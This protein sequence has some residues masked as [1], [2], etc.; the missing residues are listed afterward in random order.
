MSAV[1][2]TQGKGETSAHHADQSNTAV[3]LTGRV[4]S[5][6]PGRFGERLRVEHAVLS[7]Q[8]GTAVP[9]RP[10]FLALHGWG[11]NEADLAQLM[12]YIAPYNDF[13]ALRAPL[14]LQETPGP[15]GSP[16]AFSWFHDSVPTGE[17]L[18]RDAYAASVAVDDWVANNI[19]PDRPVVPIGFSQGGLLSVHLLRVHPER[20][21]AC[22]SLSGFLAPGI[23]PATTPA[24][25][26]LVDLHIPV[27]YGYGN[28]DMV[29]PKHETFAMIAWLEEHTWLTEKGYHG[30]GHSV[31]MEEFADIRQWLLL[32][33]ISSGLL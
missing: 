24:D 21:R 2:G 15:F 32:H 14:T 12:Q 5:V 1:D 29:I 11:S 13:A 18:D 23:I 31:G 20:Y 17:D 10:V 28:N 30:M 26:R 7:D 8:S 4:S 16:G 22:I 33:D 3:D 25:E 9:N 6:V 27:F 19:A